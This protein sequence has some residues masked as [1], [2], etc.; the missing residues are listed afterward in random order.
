MSRNRNTIFIVASG[1][2]GHIFPALAIADYLSK[3]YDIIWIGT[4]N[5]LEHKLVTKYPI[6][7]IEMSRF[8][9]KSLWQQ[10]MV[11]KSTIS[12]FLQSSKLI[13]KYHPVSIVC[14]GGYVS[15][16]IGIMAKMHSIPL[17]IH[18]QNATAGL[19]NKI[20]NRFSTKTLT[21]YSNVLTSK[22]S[23]V[24]GNPLR[25]EFN[26]IQ[27]KQ[28]IAEGK[29]NLLIVGGSLGAKYLNEHMPK[30]INQLDKIAT[31]KH[32]IGKNA[33]V[34]DVFNL[35]DK[36]D[37][38][39][40]KVVNFITDIVSEYEQ[41]DFVV[42]R[43]GALTVAEISCVGVPAL[44][45]PYPHAVDNH[46]FYNTKSLVDI[47]AAYVVEE[48]VSGDAE[49]LKIMQSMTLQKCIQMYNNNNNRHNNLCCLSN[50]AKIIHECCKD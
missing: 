7:P 33:S 26:G 6:M 13:K 45:V 22:K 27:N 24:V 3:D 20:L 17:V 11:L 42:C 40:V 16:P 5:G 36:K 9:K 4:P 43:A 10:I 46:Q 49:I 29:I 12:S 2:G 50:I 15:I 37:G 21:A 25:I 35:Y 47:G 41:A 19:S 30:I 34:E 31:V 8:R 1:T 39:S 32:Q 18:E 48:S 14:F 28:F 44:F 38:V 23:V